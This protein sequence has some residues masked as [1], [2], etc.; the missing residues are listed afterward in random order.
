MYIV[1]QT[2]RHTRS[3]VFISEI[4]SI[5]VGCWCFKTHRW[6][7]TNPHMKLWPR[8]QEEHSPACVLIRLLDTKNGEQNHKQFIYTYVDQASIHLQES[9]FKFIVKMSLYLTSLRI[10]LHFTLPFFVLCLNTVCKE[11]EMTQAGGLPGNPG[12]CVPPHHPFTPSYLPWPRAPSTPQALHS[13]SS[14]PTLGPLVSMHETHYCMDGTLDL[15]C[16]APVTTQYLSGPRQAGHGGAV[17]WGFTAVPA[18]DSTSGWLTRA[19]LPPLPL[20]AQ[21]ISVQG[22]WAGACAPPVPAVQ[23][24]NMIH[25]GP[26]LWV[27]RDWVSSTFL[28]CCRGN[29]LSIVLV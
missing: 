18:W 12:L 1:N 19:A 21:V 2:P 24:T 9:Q 22:P 7:L 23:S 28:R 8:Q 4:I 6:G 25:P 15:P 17:I 27:S 26:A 20:T 29:W 14:D 5:P 16:N 3:L 11:Q 13:C 10:T